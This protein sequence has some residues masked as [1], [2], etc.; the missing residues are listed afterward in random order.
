MNR[1]LVEKI[2]HD[3]KWFPT[4]NPLFRADLDAPM[5]IDTEDGWFDL[6][7]DLC[8]KIDVIV[9]REHLKDFGVDQVK[10]KFAGLRY[11]GHGYNDEIRKLINEAEAKSFRTCEICGSAGTTY[12]SA[13]WY[14][15]LC[16]DCA[17]TDKKHDWVK[18]KEPIWVAK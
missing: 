5:W 15:T 12:I 14:K 7:Y 8:K 11:Y 13:G 17:S 10:E 1:K 4:K 9:N 2:Q 16:A 18:L 6:I 3:F